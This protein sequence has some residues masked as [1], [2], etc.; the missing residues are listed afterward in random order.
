MFSGTEPLE[1]K[2]ET[3]EPQLRIEPAYGTRPRIF[4]VQA[5]E[6]SVRLPINNGVPKHAATHIMRREMVKRLF[7][8]LDQ[9][10]TEAS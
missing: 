9:L 10:T 7:D 2:K 3:L 4:V 1:R 5:G 8:L 6:M